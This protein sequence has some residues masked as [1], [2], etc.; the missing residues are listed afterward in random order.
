MSCFGKR[1]ELN[2]GYS[3]E[4]LRNRPFKKGQTPTVCLMVSDGFSGS[5]DLHLNQSKTKELISIL[6]DSL[7]ERKIN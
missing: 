6:K 7:E 1:I 4:L 5:F 3:L 2:C